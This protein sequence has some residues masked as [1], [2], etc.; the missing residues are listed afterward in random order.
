MRVS[1]SYDGGSLEDDSSAHRYVWSEY[2]RRWARLS[3][4]TIV[5]YTSID[6]NH[7]GNLSDLIGYSGQLTD[8]RKF[9]SALLRQEWTLAQNDRTELRWGAAT[10]YE[11]ARF[12]Y[13]RAIHFPTDLAA[14]FRREA[15]SVSSI[16][17][18]A[19]LLDYELYA[20]FN[21]ALSRWLTLDAGAHWSGVK[22]STHQ[23]SIAWDPRLG[24]LFDLSS[25]TRLRLSA[26][27]M[28]Q[29]WAATD[30]PIEQGR[31]LFD[32]RSTSNLQVVAWEHD[33]GPRL[34][35][36][37]EIFNKHVKDPRPRV[38]NF[39]FPSAVLPELRPDEVVI[40]PDSSRMKG[41]DLY[42][43][44]KFTQNVSAWLS[45][46]RSLAND[47]IDGEYVVR[48]WDQPHSGGIGLAWD[49]RWWL[50]SAEVFAH[51]N[52]PQTP[53][54]ASGPIRVVDEP[55]DS[56][57]NADVGVRNSERRGYYFTVNL[58]TE[59]NRSFA[60]G[61]LRFALELANATDHI[62][63]CCNDL[64]FFNFFSYYDDAIHETLQNRQESRSWLRVV[65]YATISFEF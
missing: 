43:T 56:A 1:S 40:E 28:T 42:A 65:P 14:F 18:S 13:Y 64:M 3:S 37:A 46:S 39:L 63:N 61:T 58:K 8:D 30:L 55:I 52:W 54:A 15:D 17:T 25:A 31:L 5:S 27:R 48:A 2:E 60:F 20:G 51:S 11:H 36:R 29:T 50:V 16:E 41:F 21:R 7:L 49:R 45:Y 10:R 19:S 6:T 47:R 9:S 4:R 24:L 23:S 12:D 35:V 38:E 33:F 59:V 44:A 34:F 26:G 57:S 22:Y 62:N 53:V 32:E